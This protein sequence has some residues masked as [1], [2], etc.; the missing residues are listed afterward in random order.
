MSPLDVVTYERDRFL[1]TLTSVVNATQECLEDC[2][3]GCQHVCLEECLAEERKSN[4]LWYIGVI[5]DTF[6]TLGGASGKQL[7][8]HAAVTKNNWFIPLGLL[9]TAVIDPVR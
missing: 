5:L 6:A 9:C 1:Q 2:R 4:E 8:R 3:D 7:L